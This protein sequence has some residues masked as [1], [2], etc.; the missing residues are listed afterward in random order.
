MNTTNFMNR[1]KTPK[2]PL[3]YFT[4]PFGRKIVFFAAGTTTVGLFLGNFLPHTIFL[5]KYQEFVQCYKD[6]VIRRV[7]NVIEA[8]LEK[9]MDI[10]KV[11]EYERKI[12]KPFIVYGFDIFS[13]GSTKSKYGGLIGIPTNYS[14]T[15]VETIDR[16]EIRFRNEQIK[17][18]SESGKML[19]EALVLT[20]D[21]QIFG[22][23][24]TILQLQ[25][26][27]VMLNSVFPSLSFLAMYSVGNYL[28]QRMNLLAKGISLR[29]VMYSI[30]GMFGFGSWSF[31]KDYN[32]VLYDT[33]IDKQLSALGPEF[34]DAG[35]RFY[36]KLLKKNM[37]L[38]ALT[39]DDT[40]TAKGNENFYLRQKCLPLT[41][42]KAFFEEEWKKLKG[43]SE[44][45]AQ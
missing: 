16:S 8:R 23:C 43:E 18:G 4:T 36:D 19:E 41:I 22:M 28:N 2:R 42:H 25:T 13:A 7:P 14:Y 38:R 32:Q 1:P 45:V 24:R 35:I 6:G 9:A 29:V 40:Y 17:W 26:Q 30:L 21:E 12:L 15:S 31:M 11:P 39:G 5:S 3:S 37:A 10:L 44:Q 20:E 33:S 27:R 34:V